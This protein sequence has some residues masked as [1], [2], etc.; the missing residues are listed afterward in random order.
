MRECSFVQNPVGANVPQRGLVSNAASHPTYQ[1]AIRSHLAPC[2]AQYHSLWQG[3]FGE[4]A[5]WLRSGLQK[6][7]HS[8][9]KKLSFIINNL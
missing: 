6:R 1:A 4:L 2:S 9:Q 7:L 8:H 3:H 5:E